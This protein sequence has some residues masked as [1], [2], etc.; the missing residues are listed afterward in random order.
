MSMCRF[1]NRDDEGYKQVSGV[2]QT[3]ISDIQ[4]RREQVALEN[5]HQLTSL[6]SDSSSQKTLAS[7][8]YSLTDA[9][10]KCF[11]ILA[12]NTATAAEYKSSLP[13]RVEGTCQWI[14]SNPQYVDWNLRKETC[15][16]W[17]SGY[18]G[19][20]KTILSAYLLEH[21][22]AQET[23]PSL[24]TRLCYFFCDE[25]IDTQRGGT[26]I[27]KSLIHQVLVGRRP[28]IK[29]VR[30]AYDVH[31]PQF[32]QNFTELWRIFIAIAS[33]ERVGPVS[34]IVDAIDECEQI[35]RDRFLRNVL[36][37]TENLRS[38][39][40]KP[41]CIKFLFTSRPLLGRQYTTN[42]L[43]IDSTQNHI[44]QDLRLVIQTKVEGIVQRTRC[45]P[46]V[47]AYLENALNS[48]AD[49]TFLW[50]TL[51]LHLLEQSF[52]ASKRD[53]KRI[54]D[55]LPKTLTATYKSLLRCIAVE[56]QPLATKLL[57][58]FVGSL[59]PLT[60]E[61]IRTLV[62]M[63][64]RH[65]NL[66]DIEEGAQP[67][68]QITIEGVLGPLVRIWDSKV[69]LIHQ[70]LKEFLQNP[71][72]QSEDPLLAIY[73]IDPCKAHLLLAKACVSY[74][75]LDD[76]EQP[77][78]SRDH[79]SIEDSP[80]YPTDM[81]SL[82]QLRDTYDIGKDDIFKEPAVLE[83][84]ACGF[85]GIQ[86]AF[87]DYS[88]KHWA[89]HFSSVSSISPHTLQESVLLLLDIN[90][91]R[92]SNWF[93]YFWL[94]AEP[95][96][97]RPAEFDPFIAASY[98]GHL[99]SVENLLRKGRSIAP[100]VGTRG[101][102]WAARMGHHKVVNLLLQE[103]FNPDPKIVD[104]QSA[105]L[106][107]V[108]FNRLAVVVRLL[109]DDGFVSE[110]EGYRVNQAG[111]RGRTPL[112]IAAANGYGEVAKQLLKHNR[113]RP[114]I[115]DFGLWTPLFWSVSGKHWDVLR[116]L[117]EDPRISVNHVDESG[118]NVL[119]WAASS[120]DLELVKHLLSL[121]PLKADEPD[122]NGQTAFLWAA[123]NGHLETTKYLR[124]SRRIDVC[125][126]DKNGRNALSWACAGRH[127]RVVEYLINHDRQGVEL[128]DV[129]GWTPLAWALFGEAPKTVQVLLDSGLADVNK[130]DRG[131]RSPL[132]WAAGNGYLGIVRM[133]LK[134]DGIEI[135]SE[136][137][138][139]MT[140]L[141]HATRFPDIVDALQTA[142]NPNLC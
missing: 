56:H 65:R 137:K 108:Q 115:A 21:L 95:D 140:P 122:R 98:F 47:K 83:S 79:S 41:S 34:V 135:T 64:D 91:P 141:S 28:L 45:K 1:P 97:T 24:P 112:C 132:S 84:E 96:L 78:F 138:G 27:V 120:G 70:S 118:R 39:G 86:Y 57:H 46:D 105:L 103:N 89:E 23:P 5:T 102:F 19:T 52:L 25:K 116:L 81:E 30:S 14:L 12:Q 125:S 123:G 54:I 63:E 121:K 128:A 129:D 88:T 26:A 85:I 66:A 107:A 93:R 71:L 101:I 10:R 124:R 109:E 60:L 119:S 6:R 62:A 139:G 94:H 44:E 16:L 130:K 92:G 73:G 43:Q 127:H 29:Y 82:E 13:D 2:I 106:A 134:V 20:G 42:P 8:A 133:L 110:E 75:L 59:K 50:V 7:T 126:K 69:Y 18:A 111:K 31:G 136:D 55:E 104:G 58:F 74:L 37:L 67:N 68:I 142:S 49:R 17:I 117:L 51:V 114:D 48:K 38:G 87:F 100:E 61:E 113:I 72:A 33:D 3:V 15:L 32:D 80:A 131:G 9:E 22:A 99:T 76:F 11:V 4:R 36:Q 90:S 40:L 77:I 53:F 35:T